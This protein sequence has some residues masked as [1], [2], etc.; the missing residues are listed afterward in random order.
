MLLTTFIL[1]AI[2]VVLAHGRSEPLMIDPPFLQPNQEDQ[3]KD[4]DKNTDG[5]LSFDE[6]LMKE[7]FWVD[8][9]RENFKNRDANGDGF[10]TLQE[11]QAYVKKMEEEAKKQM[12]AYNQEKFSEYDENKDGM[13][14]K[15]EMSAYAD[16]YLGVL[17]DKAY[18]DFFSLSDINKDGKLNYKEFKEFDANWLGANL[19]FKPV[20]IRPFIAIDPPMPTKITTN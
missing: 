19:T 15:T 3:F 13:L 1:A 5:K 6:Y 20:P 18:D 10:V 17:T 11:E 7:K 4:A 14:S 8:M 12:E 16:K 9:Q 2:C